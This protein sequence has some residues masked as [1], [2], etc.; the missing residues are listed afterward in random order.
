MRPSICRA[1]G[2]GEEP[3]HVNVQH[4]LSSVYSSIAWRLCMI[5]YRKDAEEN[6]S[7][8][9]SERKE[10]GPACH[11]QNNHSTS[12]TKDTIPQAREMEKS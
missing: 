3:P 8:H 2:R 6:V 10:H 5:G 9:I 12:Y 4:L 7:L 1:L 11:H